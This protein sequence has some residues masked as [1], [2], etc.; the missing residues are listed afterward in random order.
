MWIFY[1]SKHV[2]M[3]PG[4]KIPEFPFNF[5]FCL[6]IGLHLISAMPQL[7]GILR[8]PHFWCKFNHFKFSLDIFATTYNAVL[9]NKEPFPAAVE[10]K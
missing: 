2:N 6:I 9:P 8:T 5:V 10:H 1:T 7:P 3:N 4:F